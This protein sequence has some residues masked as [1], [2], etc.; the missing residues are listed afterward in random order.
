VQTLQE[1]DPLLVPAHS[2]TR[3]FKVSTINA[4]SADILQLIE[5]MNGAA[6]VKL[7]V[8]TELGPGVGFSEVTGFVYWY[9]SIQIPH[10]HH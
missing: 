9:S 5:P 3:P 4:G 8:A 6:G 1:I 10:S 7:T 2:C